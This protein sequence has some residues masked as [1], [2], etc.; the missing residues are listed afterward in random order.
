MD[1]VFAFGVARKATIIFVWKIVYL[2]FVIFLFLGSRSIYLADDAS[3]WF[4]KA[5][6]WAGRV[7]LVFF[8]ITSLPGMARRFGI[9]NKFFSLLMMFRRYL[10][11]TTYLLVLIHASFV[12]FVALLAGWVFLPRPLF[13]TFGFVAHAGLFFMFLTSNDWSV[14]RLGVWWR[15][16]H[17]LFYLI[18]WLIFGH[19]A[20]QRVSIW[21]VLIG[22]TGIAE[23][24]SFVW[25][26]IKQS[27]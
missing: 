12:R 18:M 25:A 9:R 2:L 27:T 6:V 20:I 10:G 15:R 22:M 14:A 17:S 23:V 13:E 11:I 21:S 16:I 7:A 24:A 8:V 19:I 3:L 4:Y 5:G 26:R 1:K